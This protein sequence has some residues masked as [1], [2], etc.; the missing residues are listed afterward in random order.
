MDMDMDM[1]GPRPRA[2]PRPGRS[3][4]GLVLGLLWC[5]AGC[6]DMG[7]VQSCLSSPDDCPPGTFCDFMSQRCVD[8]KLSLVQRCES[9]ASCKD[10]A[11][12]FCPAGY[13]VPCSDVLPARRADEMCQALEQGASESTGNAAG[14]LKACVYEGLRKGQCGECR[15]ETADV[16]GV[17]CGDPL[18]PVCDGGACRPCKQHSECSD[19]GICNDGS[20]LFDVAGVM[21]GQCMPREKVIFADA[22]RC[23]PSGVG[24]EGTAERPFCDLDSAVRVAAARGSYVSVRPRAAPGEVYAPLVVAGG[25]RVILVGAGRDRP[26]LLSAVSASGAGTSVFLIDVPLDS[27][28][29][30]AA[31]A[32]SAGARLSLIRGLLDLNG[33]TASGVDATGCDSLEIVESHIMRSRGPAVRTGTGTRT[34]R[35]VNSLFTYN[36]SV[37]P[38]AIVLAAGASGVFAY[39]TIVNNGPM[40]QDGGAVRC[41]AGSMALLSDSLILQN[42]RS[43]R[44]DPN[45]TPLGTQ[46]SGSCRLLRVVVGVDAAAF[47]LGPGVAIAAIPDLT[48]KLRL[49]DTPNN[50]TCCVDKGAACDDLKQDYFG[51]LRQQGKSCDLGAHE[52]R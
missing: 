52:L 10:G 23:P 34:Y 6:M 1:S 27:H 43:L 45:G 33:Q 42:G 13:C 26:P 29:S 8:E 47:T 35:I 50:A 17:P 7:V 20:G 41:D 37:G 39:N 16:P 21:L 38:S 3:I 28:V 4:E 18:R 2:W 46:F 22:A 9:S 15:K 40:D 14:Q 24:A 48:N 49:L 30:G 12:P 5:L 36:A 25:K 11:R 19:S 31:L 32:C 44:T 51:N